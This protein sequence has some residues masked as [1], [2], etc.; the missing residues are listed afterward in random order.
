MV[1]VRSPCKMDRT[2]SQAA[3]QADRQTGRRERSQ[4]AVTSLNGESPVRGQLAL[5]CWDGRVET[6]LVSSYQSES[7]RLSFQSASSLAHSLSQHTLQT[8]RRHTA[9]TVTAPRHAT[10]SQAVLSRVSTVSTPARTLLRV[11]QS[12]RRRRR[13]HSLV[14]THSHNS[15]NA[16][17]NSSTEHQCIRQSSH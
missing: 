17:N 7:T 9:H 10:L 5:Y 15:S 1:D 13:Y 2:T 6:L 14:N 12:G 8:P 11:E 4:A 3:S 16:I